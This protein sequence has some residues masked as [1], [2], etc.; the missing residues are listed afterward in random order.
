MNRWPP[1][2]CM[3][4]KSCL[5]SRNA[6]PRRRRLPSARCLSRK[7]RRRLRLCTSVHSLTTS[8]AKNFPMW[9]TVWPRGVISL[10]TISAISVGKSPSKFLFSSMVGKHVCA[11]YC[12]QWPGAWKRSTMKAIVANLSAMGLLLL[13]WIEKSFKWHASSWHTICSCGQRVANVAKKQ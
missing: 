6:A 7:A 9:R 8:C 13:C 10:F 2:D 5:C 3:S 12:P 1:H 4:R 11:Q